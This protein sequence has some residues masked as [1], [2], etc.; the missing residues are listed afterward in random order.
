M[1]GREK[2]EAAFSEGGTREIPAVI[3]YEGIYYRDRWEEVTSCPWWYAHTCDLEKQ[4]EWRTN[5]IERIGQDWVVLAMCASREDRASITVEERAGGVYEVDRRT[6]KRERIERPPVGGW[7]LASRMASVHPEK[8]AQTPKEID[9]LLAVPEG[10][11]AEDV[12]RQG[13]DDLARM[14]M[15][16]PGRDLYPVYYIASPFWA[17][18]SLWGFEGMM[19]MIASRKDMVKY[20]CGRALARAIQSVREAA[21]LG[22]RGIWIEECLTDMISPA[23][24]GMLNVP[25]LRG[26]VDAI[27]AADMKAIY[28]YCGSPDGKWDEILSV[29]AD[30]VSFEES[31]KGFTID[32][33]DVVRRV[34]GRA[35]VLG[36]LDAIGLL[37]NGTDAELAAEISRQ[38]VAGRRNSGRF[39]MSIGSPVTPGTPMARV[40]LYTDLVREVGS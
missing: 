10:V 24:F 27:H 22:A 7:S 37:P 19:L 38:I 39:I 25:P 18:Y 31:K 14:V 6:G 21:V 20:A 33:D 13:R 28:Y 5:A 11:D 15:A 1:T 12:S 23:D 32:I 40:R 36:N 4:I 35:V 29:G 3:C 16:G 2:I 30:A 9:T 17:L 34:D 8:L 26:M